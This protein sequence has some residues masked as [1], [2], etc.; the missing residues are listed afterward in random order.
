MNKKERDLSSQLNYERKQLPLELST[1]SK[2]EEE[3]LTTIGSKAVA[4]TTFYEDKKPLELL[5]GHLLHKLA[6]KEIICDKFRAEMLK[7]SERL[8]SLGSISDD[9]ILSCQTLTRIPP[10]PAEPDGRHPLRI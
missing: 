3:K 2:E 9:N 4:F 7:V 10:S 8:E 6:L 1:L 5:I